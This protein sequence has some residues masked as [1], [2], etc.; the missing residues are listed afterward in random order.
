MTGRRSP[1]S[2]LLLQRTRRAPKSAALILF[3]CASL[4]GAQA[5][6]DTPN[7]PTPQQVPAPSPLTAPA[8][9]SIRTPPDLAIPHSN[10]PL[11]AYAPSTVA[12]PNLA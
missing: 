12:K 7:A 10:N 8:P 5:Q 11:K 9:V 2:L 3:L 1:S 4:L 6:Q